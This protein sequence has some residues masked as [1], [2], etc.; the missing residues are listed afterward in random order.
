MSADF[1]ATGFHDRDHVGESMPET[2]TEVGAQGTILLDR[3][4][5]LAYIPFGL[6]LDKVC[7]TFVVYN[8]L[9]LWEAIST[10]SWD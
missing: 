9:R 8:H 10:W 5:I 1:A 2:E 6:N 4:S 3:L 7:R